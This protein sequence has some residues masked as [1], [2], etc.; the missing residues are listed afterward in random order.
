MIVFLKIVTHFLRI[1]LQ[2]SSK[3]LYLKTT[4]SSEIS[5]VLATRT[6]VLEAARASSMQASPRHTSRA[7]DK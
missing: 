2:R 4:I 7:E 1:C 6:F 5:F 3:Y